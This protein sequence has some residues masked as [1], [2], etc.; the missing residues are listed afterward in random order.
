M[1]DRRSYVMRARAEAVEDTRRRILLAVHDLGRENMTMEIVLADVADR[2]GVSV[3]TIL[4][5]FRNREGLFTAMLEFVSTEL[6]HDRGTPAT[7]DERS[8]VSGQFDE[9]EDNGDFVITM[10]GRENTDPT[11]R[12]MTDRG[13]V[14]HRDWVRSVFGPRV[15][16]GRP[17]EDVIDLPVVATD[18]Y[19]WKL[20]RRDRGLDRAE[21]EQRVRRL[22][23][24]LTAD[25]APEIET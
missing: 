10:L 13:R 25:D 3:R 20:L 9:Y 14:M 16:P 11:V 21:A 24:M 18:V 1:N 4:R 17:V 6:Q 8:A 2:A 19:T 23:T 5:H 15:P 7:G 22:V 12:R